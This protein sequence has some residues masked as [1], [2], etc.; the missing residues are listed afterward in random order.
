MIKDLFLRLL[1]KHL[2]DTTTFAEYK[3]NSTTSL[4]SGVTTTVP[5]NT[6]VTS[7]IN[8]ELSGTTVK[9]LATGK[10]EVKAR[11]YFNANAVG[12]RSIG[13]YVNDIELKDVNIPGSNIA[14]IIEIS[15]YIILSANDIITYKLT[16]DSG[17]A[18]SSVADGRYCGIQVRRVG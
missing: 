4:P 10:Y 5:L 17:S 15:V 2:A 8:S 16:Q 11:A 12:S 3:S 9:I 7:D 14:V 13:I 1:N 18:L 6:T